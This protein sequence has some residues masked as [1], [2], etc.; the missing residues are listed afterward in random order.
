MMKPNKHRFAAH[1]AEVIK[2]LAR[3]RRLWRYGRRIWHARTE[4]HVGATAIV[5][6]DP[7]FQDAAQMR[8]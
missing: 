6:G 3:L 5:M 2:L 4:R 7:R 1:R 8:F